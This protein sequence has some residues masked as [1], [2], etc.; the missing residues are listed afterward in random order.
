MTVKID[1][2]Q[3]TRLGIPRDGRI[4]ERALALTTDFMPKIGAIK[5]RIPYDKLVTQDFL[6]R[7]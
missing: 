7:P 2:P 1:T 6:P 3:K 4:T 5:A